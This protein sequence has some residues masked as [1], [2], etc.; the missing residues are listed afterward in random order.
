MLYK[1]SA[2]FVSFEITLTLYVPRYTHMAHL[3]N[4]YRF[5]LYTIMI[6][7]ET[8]SVI[9]QMEGGLDNKQNT[10]HTNSNILNK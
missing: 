7:F 4:L 2:I 6:D 10:Q 5:Y 3:F 9:M 1:D 8:L